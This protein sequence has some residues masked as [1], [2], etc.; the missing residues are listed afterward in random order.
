MFQNKSLPKAINFGH[1]LCCD[2]IGFVKLNR[3]SLGNHSKDCQRF[4][5]AIGLI[6]VPYCT[7]GLKTPKISLRRHSNLVVERCQVL[8][9]CYEDIFYFSYSPGLLGTNNHEIY[10]E[11]KLPDGRTTESMT[12]FANAWEVSGDRTCLI[13]ESRPEKPACNKAPSEQCFKLLKEKKSKYSPL[14]HVVNPMPFL[15]A[16]QIDSADCDTKE[17]YETSHCNATAAY[18]QMLRLKGV[19]ARLPEDCGKCFI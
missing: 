19:W 14:F 12:K 9:N 4:I 15:K 5:D 7:D 6:S 1:L 10:D 2:T 13:S 18:V 3:V 16:C 8:P 17:P 11:M